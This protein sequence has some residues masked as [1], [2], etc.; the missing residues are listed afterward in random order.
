MLFNFKRMIV[1]VL[2]GFL[3]WGSYGQNEGS[4]D[5][6]LSDVF[7]PSPT[8]ASIAQYGELPVNYYTGG[9]NLSIPIH[10][11][12]GKSLAVPI[13]L[14][15]S[16]SGN[17]VDALASWIGDGWAA[18][19]GGVI[20]RTLRG[21]KDERPDVGYWAMD[22]SMPDAF[23]N[24][25]DFLH[26]QPSLASKRA[27][28]EGLYDAQPDMFQFSFLNYAGKFMIAPD[29]SVHGMPAHR[30]RITFDPSSS[31]SWF[32]VTTPDGNTLLFEDK[33]STVAESICAGSSTFNSF[34]SSWYLS[35]IISADR[36]DTVYFEYGNASITHP[37]S[38]S[39]TDY[40]FAAVQSQIGQG[41]CAFKPRSICYSLVDTDIK[42]L[43]KIRTLRETVDFY[44]N[45]TRQDIA[46]S[47]MLDSI[48]VKRKGL[49][50]KSFHLAH[51]YFQAHTGL[52]ATFWPS[53]GGV[54]RMKRLRLDSL[55]EASATGERLPAYI[56]DY[57][58]KKIAPY[59]SFA[60]DHWGYFNGVRN[61][62]L[63]PEIPLFNGS[64]WHGA[65]R[66][67]NP[68]FAVAGMLEKITYPT[69]GFISFAY[70]G[71]DCGS[72]GKNA[73]G[74]MRIKKQTVHD[75][76]NHQHDIVKTYNY[77]HPNNPQN[78]SGV[79]LALPNYVYQVWELEV[80]SGQSGS[81]NNLPYVA[82]QCLHWAR[83]SSS[84]TNLA[85]TKGS[86]VGYGYV[87]EVWG[88]NGIGGKTVMKFRTGID[89]VVMV[90]PFT[91]SGSN[92]HKRGQLLSK[93]TYNANGDLVQKEEN[94]YAD[95]LVYQ[96]G[97][98]VCSY[99][100][101]HIYLGPRYQKFFFEK[102]F[103]KSEWVF[104]KTSTITQYDPVSSNS[105]AQVTTY[106]YDNPAH[107][108]PTRIF[109]TLSDGRISMQKKKYPAD[110]EPIVI[111]ESGSQLTIADVLAKN[112]V[113]TVIEEQNWEGPDAQNL[114][115]ISGKLNVLTDCSTDPDPDK[116]SIKP[117]AVWVLEAENPITESAFAPREHFNSNSGTY[118][119]LIP[120]YTQDFVANDY[121]KRAAFRFGEQG[122]LL[123]QK[124]AG[125]PPTAY[126]WNEEAYL[127]LAK[128]VNA[129][130]DEIAYTSFETIG[131]NNEGGFLIQHANGTT[132]GWIT[133]SHTGDNSFDLSGKELAWTAPANV[134]GEFVLSFMG[135]YG[136]FST[137]L[138]STSAPPQNGPN[139]WEYREFH[140]SLTAGQTVR[141]YGTGLVDEVRL[142]PA[143]ALFE[144]T[145]SF[146]QRERVIN[147]A[148]SDGKAQ[149]FEYDTFNR[150]QYIK[151]VEG[152]YRQGILYHYKK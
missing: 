15:Y 3:Y 31:L 38:R 97:G 30:L 99:R 60:M 21:M 41:T 13:S 104:P 102:F 86:P 106:K 32:N 94:T 143:D 57:N 88:R 10:V 133:M 108:L 92:D 125:G 55:Y 43:K 11:A 39:E 20:S 75:G 121:V 14:S 54:D 1:G 80:A 149:T 87:T 48:V 77:T 127:P 115:L 46:N 142:M 7:P 5:P 139:G 44:S 61:A 112:M 110:Y 144:S 103:V 40:K 68:T 79:I 85:Y 34:T 62:S 26:W 129:S 122:N 58:S 49:K 51:A 136:T 126:I 84:K 81:G 36:L 123:E 2:L 59:G 134:S 78:S 56:F 22:D 89:A 16:S 9:L 119:T 100:K 131:K 66:E 23:P 96:M 109:K 138:T 91:P 120:D 70:E 152:N 69:G 64:P 47:R 4:A 45:G 33:E 117:F 135:R 140:F 147:T 113:E 137:N 29:G 65:N 130:A 83:G 53:G 72:P 107:F 52:T 42:Y 12:Q 146:D 76:A 27:L 90:P 148:G 116:S 101:K 73:I 35:K 67:A 19:A 71:N 118:W 24:Q 18:Q 98:V 6:L 82:R 145:Y 25:N 8:A 63:L 151:D 128:V 111:V 105:F 50:M 95:S 132:G 141:L 74:G 150:L 28:A 17:K 124:L 37:L 114:S 93:L